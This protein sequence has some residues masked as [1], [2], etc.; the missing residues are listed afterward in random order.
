MLQ[1]DNDEQNRAQE[2]G[3]CSEPAVPSVQEPL[4]GQKFNSEVSFTYSSR[5][6]Q[7]A[8]SGPPLPLTAPPC[9]DCTQAVFLGTPLG[10]DPCSTHLFPSPQDWPH[11][12]LRACRSSSGI[13]CTHLQE[14]C[15]QTYQARKQGQCSHLGCKLEHGAGETREN[16]I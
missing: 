5:P 8:I 12:A 13:L 10:Q 14:R 16:G 15:K 6:P 11:R 7:G 4:W 3:A 1:E 2:E 9:R